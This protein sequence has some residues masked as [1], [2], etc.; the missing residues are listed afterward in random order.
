MNGM[1]EDFVAYMIP[2]YTNDPLLK[3]T[4]EVL[5]ELESEG[6]NAYKNAKAQ[7]GQKR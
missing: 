4:D 1:L 6:L 5:A 2:D 3:K 7:I